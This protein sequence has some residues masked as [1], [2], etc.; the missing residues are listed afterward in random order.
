MYQDAEDLPTE[1]AEEP[2]DKDAALAYIW[3]DSEALLLKRTASGSSL[4]GR[5]LQNLAGLLAI[6]L[7]TRGLDVRG[8]I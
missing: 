8:G 2:A 5:A 1:V 3:K 4:H 6:R 7:P